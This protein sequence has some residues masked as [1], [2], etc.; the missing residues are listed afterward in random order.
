MRTGA[1]RWKLSF[2][3]DTATGIK[4]N[5]N[6]NSVILQLQNARRIRNNGYRELF[7]LIDGEFNSLTRNRV[8][9]D[10]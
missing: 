8:V 2:P 10:Q 1:P 7:L 5:K 6:K 3:N 4:I 9:H